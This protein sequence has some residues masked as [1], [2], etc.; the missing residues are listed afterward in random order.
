M[1]SKFV[2]SL[3]DTD[4]HDYSRR[5]CTVTS[6]LAEAEAALNEALH[7]SRSF[8]L[9]MLRRVSIMANCS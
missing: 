4:G 5:T 6:D 7:S 1:P 2:T 9:Q 3:E 8:L